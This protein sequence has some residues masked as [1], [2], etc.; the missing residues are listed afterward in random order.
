MVRASD[1]KLR[2]HLLGKR[3][4]PALH[5]VAHDRAADL[6]RH[7]DAQAHGGVAIAAFADKQDE[8]GHWC[9]RSA[10]G[11]KEIRAAPER[12][13]PFGSQAD[14]VLRPRAR[15]AARTLRPP[16]VALR[17]RKP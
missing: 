8:T 2:E 7:S 13:E 11:R 4:E 14:S 15:R 17:A 6:L 5:P 9:P 16:G 10:I 3:A 12:G 1:S